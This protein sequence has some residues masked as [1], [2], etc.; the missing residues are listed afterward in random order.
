MQ[1]LRELALGKPSVEAQ[2]LD[3]LADCLSHLANIPLRKEERPAVQETG[4]SVGTGAEAAIPPIHLWLA[5]L[6]VGHSPLPFVLLFAL[7]VYQGEGLHASPLRSIPC[8]P[9]C[10]RRLLRRSGSA[11]MTN[12]HV[13]DEITLRGRLYR[14]RGFSPMSVDDGRV[15]LEDVETNDLTEVATEEVCEGASS[16][17]S[18]RQARSRGRP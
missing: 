5:A 8:L 7:V 1:A 16:I 2:A 17:R 10:F 15:L 6:E 14:V 12:F 13:G 3:S 18:A 11:A 4:R 9:G